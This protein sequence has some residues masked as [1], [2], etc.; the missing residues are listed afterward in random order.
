MFRFCNKISNDIY[1]AILLTFKICY[2]VYS[3]TFT[4]VSKKLIRVFQD[5]CDEGKIKSAVT[6]RD[7]I[8][9]SYTADSITYQILQ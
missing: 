1:H 3:W 6:M 7:A 4:F 8:V 2:F 5:Y 9:F